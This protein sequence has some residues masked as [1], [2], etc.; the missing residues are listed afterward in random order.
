MIPTYPRNF[1]TGVIKRKLHQTQ[2][3]SI[4]TQRHIQSKCPLSLSP[5]NFSASSK[6]RP[7]HRQKVSVFQLRT[8]QIKTYTEQ[9]NDTRTTLPRKH[10]QTITTSATLTTKK[11]LHVK[12]Q[13]LTM[14]GSVRYSFWSMYLLALA[15]ANFSNGRDFPAI[16]CLSFGTSLET[17]HY[18]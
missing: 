1:I 3:V 14:A 4:F 7:Q 8:Y 12:K 15:T 16:R 10:T 6:T 9:K 18:R 17:R 13:T 11:N 2:S 5:V